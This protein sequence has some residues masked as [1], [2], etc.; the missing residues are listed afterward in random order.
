MSKVLRFNTD[1]RFRRMVNQTM[2]PINMTPAREQL[3]EVDAGSTLQRKHSMSLSAKRYFT[4]VN[5]TVLSKADAGLVAAGM[6]TAYPLF[7]LGEFDRQGGYKTGLATL[8]PVQVPGTTPPVI[9]TTFVNG[10]TGT[11][12][13]VVTPLSPFNTI[14]ALL[15]QGDIVVV[16]T[17]NVQTPTY[18]C[19][20]VV[21]NPYAAMSS[22]MANL[23]S[24]QADRRLG[25]LWCYEINW[26]APAAQW[27]KP[28]NFITSDNLG[29]WRNNPVQPYIF[30]T[31]YNALPDFI[32]VKTSFVLDQF[33]LIALMYDLATDNMTFNFNIQ[34]VD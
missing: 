24:S 30:D 1:P 7:L 9:F 3:S 6:A 10:A 32:T 22:I 19:F 25:P 34:K 17:D 27:E 33:M 14:Q 29:T 4:D 13:N 26:Y 20:M 23:V 8:Q 15:K 31:I 21:S 2:K 5:G 16:Y 18:F 28:L 12:N 11:S